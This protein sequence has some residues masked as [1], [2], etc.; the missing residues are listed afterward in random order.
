MKGFTRSNP[1]QYSPEVFSKVMEQVE[2]FEENS[3]E[4]S[5]TEGASDS[6]SPS[7]KGTV[8]S[9]TNYYSTELTAASHNPENDMPDYGHVHS[10]N[11]FH[12]GDSVSHSEY[13]TGQ[14][15]SINRYEKSIR[16]RFQNG[17]EQHFFSNLM[18]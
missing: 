17:K 18:T 12:V 6:R 11:D 5:A 1:P 3:W 16:I 14:V 8:F 13:G 9:F 2:N 15:T 4:A 7:G 10:F